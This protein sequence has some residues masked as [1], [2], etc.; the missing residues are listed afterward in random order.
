MPGQSIQEAIYTLPLEGG[1]VEIGEGTHNLS[2]SVRILSNNI[3]LTGQ[4]INKTFLEGGGIYIS[5][6]DDG[7][8]QVAY[9]YANSVKE[10]TFHNYSNSN[11]GDFV[12]D[13]T[14]SSLTLHNPV[15][16]GINIVQGWNIKY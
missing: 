1:V 6:Y 11:P 8:A 7:A 10:I 5:K 15:T 3:T 14:V 9:N 4:G 13:V 12:K 16:D 2:A